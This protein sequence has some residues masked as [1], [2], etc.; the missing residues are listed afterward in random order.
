[1]LCVEPSIFSRWD[2]DVAELGVNEDD[3][4]NKVFGANASIPV[5]GKRNPLFNQHEAQRTLTN[6]I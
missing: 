6:C 2:R 3:E 5:N 1:M 4:F